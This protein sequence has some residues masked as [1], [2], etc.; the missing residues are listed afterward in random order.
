MRIRCRDRGMGGA[1]FRIK[2]V[3]RLL[4]VSTSGSKL[5]QIE[6]GL[7][8]K[9]AAQRFQYHVALSL[10]QASHILGK[11]TRPFQ[12]ISAYIMC[13]LVVQHRAELCRTVELLAK[14]ARTGKC[15][16][17][18]QWPCVAISALPRAIC[19]FSSCWV[20]SSKVGQDREQVQ[21]LPQSHRRFR[22]GRARHRLLASGEPIADSIF[23][24]PCFRP[25]MSKDFG[26][27][28]PISG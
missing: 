12:F 10:A 22:H 25:V 17:R 23:G 21:A 20:T 11:R 6:T 9:A 18:G 3:K 16:S 19:R 24:E 13:I 4:E 27:L 7:S 26:L 14:L 15:L 8:T 2:K 1:M 28:P 5:A